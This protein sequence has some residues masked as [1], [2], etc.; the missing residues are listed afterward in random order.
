MEIANSLTVDAAAEAGLPAVQ[1]VQSC[2]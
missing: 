1:S 2:R